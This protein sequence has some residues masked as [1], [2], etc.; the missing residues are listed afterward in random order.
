[1]AKKQANTEFFLSVDA[2][3]QHLDETGIDEKTVVFH[4]VFK[5]NKVLWIFKTRD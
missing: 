4:N 3:R 1:M 5:D 2:L